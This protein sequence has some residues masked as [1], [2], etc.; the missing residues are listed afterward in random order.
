MLLRLI[1][2]SLFISFIYS[3]SCQENDLQIKSTSCDTSGN[4]WLFKIPKDDRTCDINDL[5]LPRKV[6]NC[7]ITCPSGMH[8]NLLSENCEVCPSGTYSTG[9]MLEVTKWDSMPDFLT[10]DT[11]YGSLSNVKCNLTGWSPQGKHLVGKT[12]DSCTVILSM[13]VYNLKPGTITF[14]YQ[15]QEYGGLA[16][17]IIRNERCTQLPGGSFL[18]GLTGSYAYETVTFSVPVGHNILQWYLLVENVY[19]QRLYG[20]KDPELHIKE[21]RLTGTPPVTACTPCAAG[22]FGPKEKA[23]HCE[24]CPRDTYS[25]EGAKSCQSCPADQ[26]SGNG[27]SSCSPRPPCKKDDYTSYWTSCDQQE[28]TQR[29]WKWIEPKICD[30]NSGVSLPE[31]ES[32]VHCHKCPTGTF[33][34]DGNTCELCSI[35]MKKHL[36]NLEACVTCP[37]N[38]VPMYGLRFDNWYRMP[39]ILKLD[40]FNFFGTK[41]NTWERDLTLLRGGVG[42]HSDESAILELP[43]KDGFITAS[44]LD[45]TDEYSFYF[46]PPISNTFVRIEFKLDCIGRCQFSMKQVFDTGN[47]QTIAIWGGSSNRINYTYHIKDAS[48][49][50]F[51]WIFEKPSSPIHIQD[52]VNIYQIEVTNVKNDNTIGCQTCVQGIVD[53]KCKTCPYG[54]YFSIQYDEINKTNIINCTKCPNNSIVVGD[55]SSLHTVTEACHLCEPGTIAVNHSIC[56]T[57]TQP[58]TASGFQYNLTDVIDRVH[59]VSSPKMFTPS[60]TGYY[61]EFLISMAYGKTVQC[62]ENSSIYDQRTVNASI[63]RHTRFEASNPKRTKTYSKPTRLAD[64]LIRMVPSNVTLDFWQEVNK[65]LTKAGWMEDKYGNDLHYVFASDDHSPNCPHGRTTVITLRCIFTQNFETYMYQIKDFSE[66]ITGKIELPPLCPD[67]TCDGCT[68]HFLWTSM[69]GCRMCQEDDYEKILG[70]CSYGHRQVH[71]RAPWECRVP[72]DRNLTLIERCPLL[73]R[74]QTAAV[75]LTL[76]ILIILG[77]IIFMCHRRNKK[78]EYKYMKLVQSTSG[79]NQVTSCALEGDGD[80]DKGGSIYYT[81]M[82]NSNSNSNSDSYNKTRIKSPPSYADSTGVVL[83]PNEFLKN[84]HFTQMGFKGLP[85]VNLPPIIFKAKSDTD[86]DILTE[87][88]HVL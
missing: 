56:V 61:H 2:F 10:S 40:C 23:D 78:L 50:K 67:G 47:E 59:H 35:G 77:L 17:F 88:D 73:S 83:E 28:M 9:D 33:P 57:D 58:I 14:T 68:Y 21:I 62:I 6:D 3:E 32:P 31:S 44:T 29:K 76:I 69:Y 39:S 49:V 43:I 60:G 81:T 52:H 18:L 19:I 1:S 53:G 38:E 65:N 12:T 86:R 22:S 80:M 46:Q 84:D 25:A 45:S 11:T 75:L 74:S 51:K 20:L 41:C 5:S 66:Y 71:L 8:L 48:E 36:S 27:S 54:L 63:C 26:Y 16:F 34:L 87:N 13:K 70:E 4:R 64:R 72:Q 82:N 42:M 37:T 24:L 85:K 30:E 79:K 7:E 55:A 15:I